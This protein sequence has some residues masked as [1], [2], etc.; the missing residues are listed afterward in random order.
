MNPGGDIG[1]KELPESLRRKFCEIY[2]PDLEE[3]SDLMIL[4]GS[5]IG[6]LTNQQIVEKVVDFYLSLRKASEKFEI[7]VLKIY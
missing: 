5:I 6:N 7:E 3:K 1:K 4:V 2:V